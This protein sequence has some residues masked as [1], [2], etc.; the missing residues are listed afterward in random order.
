MSDYRR[1][2]ESCV[3]YVVRAATIAM[4]Q[5]GNTPQQQRC[6]VFCAVVL[7]GYKVNKEDCLSQLSFETPACQD[8]S[9]VVEQLSGELRVSLELAVERLRRDGKKGRL[10]V[11][12]SDS[13]TIIKPL[14]G[15]YQ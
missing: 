12:C 2:L 10:H 11:C 13:E 5:H 1:G 14:S 7:R 3:F 6:C 9:L 4:Q 15:H 8:M